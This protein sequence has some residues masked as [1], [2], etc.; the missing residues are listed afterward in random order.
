M[1][2]SII[3]KIAE[4]LLR[5]LGGVTIF[6]GGY[7]LGTHPSENLIDW[8]FPYVIGYIFILVSLEIRDK[9]PL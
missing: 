9:N 1:K 2:K 7:L 4:I 6:V 3:M 8:I 5:A